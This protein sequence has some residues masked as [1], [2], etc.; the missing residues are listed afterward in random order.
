MNEGHDDFCSSSEWAECLETDILPR[1][2]VGIDLGDHLI[3]VGP[4]FGLATEVLRTK[5]DRVTSV[6][7]DPGY[8]A[9]L[10]TRFGGTNVEVIEGDATALAFDAGTFTS[11]AC[12]TML[13]H[14]PTAE[15]QDRLFA[16]VAR[17]L[18]PG[19]P[20]VGSDSLDSAGFREFHEGDTCN[21]VDASTLAGRLRAA[22]FVDVVTRVEQVMTDEP[23]DELTVFFVA[24]CAAAREG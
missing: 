5:V 7:I 24:T 14:I 10:K 6:E 20:Y 9:A 12:F 1:V 11:A 23:G 22:G 2:L 18:R 21:P 4:G 8:A 15:L 16:G 17:V 19:A 13:H 3:E